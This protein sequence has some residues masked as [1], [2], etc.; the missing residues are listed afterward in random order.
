MADEPRN[1]IPNWAD[2][3]PRGAVPLLNAVT[4]TGAGTAFVLPKAV[5]A[6]GLEYFRATTSATLESTKAN[7]TI[8]G[9]LGSTNWHTIG[10]ALAV[11]SATPAVAR[12]TNSIPFTE[13]R[14]T[15]TSFSTS[16]GAASTAENRITTSVYATFGSGSS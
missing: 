10:A 9:R 16:A 2:G 1:Y 7:V 8:Q 13:I 14:A 3:S 11:N 4:T 5:S 6:I 12:S 15:I